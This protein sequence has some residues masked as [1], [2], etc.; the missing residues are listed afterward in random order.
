MTKDFVLGEGVS[1]NAKN[2]SVQK[3]IDE[4]WTDPIN[5]MELKQHIKVRELGIYGE[6]CYPAEVNPAN[7]HVILNYVDPT[8]ITKV[9][10][11]PENVE[12]LLYVK[13]SGKKEPYRIIDFDRDPESETFN[14]L[15]GNCFFCAI[16]RVSNSTR[17]RSDLLT[18]ADFIDG[19]DSFLF[20]RLERAKIL[21][22][23]FWDVEL[24]GKSEE[25]IKEW[26]KK[27]P[28]PRPGSMRAH[29]EKVKWNAVV[30]DLL[31]SD[32]SEEAKLIRSHI[33]SGA[34]IPTHWMGGGEGI[35]RAT[36]LAMGTPAF[37]HFKTRQ[38]EVK[39]FF[40]LIIRYVIDQAL[41]YGALDK[42]LKP[43]DLS[44]QIIFPKLEE[45]GLEIMASAISSVI[46]SISLARDNEW[47]T[48]DEARYIT[49]HVLA[50][51][52]IELERNP[53]EQLAE[54]KKKDDSIFKNEEYQ[55]ALKEKIDEV[56]GA[57]KDNA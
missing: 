11:N 41:I 12:Q 52:G 13:V 51:I 30:V 31:A 29:N 55:K 28:L 35:T 22:T 47:V 5:N 46:Q 49:R 14:K 43:E 7:G 42:N 37:K 26:L 33:L 2:D 6:Q 21:N 17:G 45:K 48:S 36:A 18:L 40:T 54:S 34:G 10:P 20:N 9:I 24:Q 4:F 57:I 53:V 8:K 23:F 16:N 39:A 25:E 3:I 19:Y 15:Q 1:T 56:K 27:T 44:F 38:L 50:L 32:A